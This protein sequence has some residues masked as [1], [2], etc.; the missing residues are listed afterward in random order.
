M[1]EARQAAP[2][3]NVCPPLKTELNRNGVQELYDLVCGLTRDEGG[4]LD[5]GEYLV[6]RGSQVLPVAVIYYRHNHL[7][8][9]VPPV[10]S[11]H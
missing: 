7:G 1:L 4:I 6:S 10:L 2:M 8:V 5:H 3:N 11:I 9:Q